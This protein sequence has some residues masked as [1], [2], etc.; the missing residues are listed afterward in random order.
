MS[1]PRLRLTLLLVSLAFCS[2][3]AL[4]QGQLNYWQKPDG[5]GGQLGEENLSSYPQ[6]TALA[7]SGAG[8]NT[9]AQSQPGAVARQPTAT[10]KLEYGLRRAFVSPE[11][12]LFYGMSTALT[13]AHEKSQPQKNT[14]DK[15]VD[16]ITRYAIT[17]GTGSTKAL[18]ASGVYPILFNEDPKY[19]WSRRQTFRAR[20]LHAVS[21]VVI[22]EN[23]EGK[24]KPNFSLLAGDVTAAS[25][26]NFWERN[27]AGHRRTGAEPTL[28]RLGLMVGF[29]AVRFVLLKEFG[30][31]I[32]RKL[33]RK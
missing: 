9:R 23:S 14:G 6:R 26:A 15:F 10:E 5:K 1:R 25:L 27:T 22:T 21:R 12:Y 28:K 32:K 20:L 31:S 2:Q 30:S 16:D 18:L 3:T 7:D 29:D 33:L 11:A 19:K 13:Q 4:T 8:L 17:F 24:Q